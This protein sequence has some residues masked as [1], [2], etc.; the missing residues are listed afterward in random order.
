MTTETVTEPK[1]RRTVLQRK[2]DAIDC[3]LFRIISELESLADLIK[4]A[5]PSLR[6]AAMEVSAARPFVRKLMHEYDRSRT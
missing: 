2:A 1:I 3:D 6:R 5:G 4:T